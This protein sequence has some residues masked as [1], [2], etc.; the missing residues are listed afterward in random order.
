[1]SKNRGGARPGAGRPSK[2]TALQRLQIG[3]EIERRLWCRTQ[4]LFDQSIEAK[5]D[6][7]GLLK[8]NW[9][10]IWAMPVGATDRCR[11]KPAALQDLL[12]DNQIMIQDGGLRGQQYFRGPSKVA[13]GIRE[14]IIRS[15]ALEAS[16]LLQV[17]VLPRTAEKC[18]EEFRAREKKLAADLA[19]YEP[20][21]ASD[22]ADEV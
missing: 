5:S 7:D 1:M 21:I 20:V 3:A 11:V 16:R 10:R 4:A 19:G 18:L 6:D 13:A 14:P 22:K 9:E 15:V 17:A 12:D 2:L 8:K